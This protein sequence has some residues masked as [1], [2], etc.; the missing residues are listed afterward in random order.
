MKEGD[1]VRV[2]TNG[3]PPLDIGDEVII[4]SR[5][6]PSVFGENNKAWRVKRKDG[7]EASI[8]EKHIEKFKITNWRQ[9]L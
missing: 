3:C 8:F 7:R 6:S 4:Q 1:I 9:E 5:Y 2:L